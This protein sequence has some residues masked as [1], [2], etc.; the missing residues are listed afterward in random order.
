MSNIENLRITVNNVNGLMGELCNR[1]PKLHVH[2]SYN[3]VRLELLDD[4]KVYKELPCIGP[5]ECLTFAEG[6]ESA[7][8]LFAYGHEK[9]GAYVYG[10]EK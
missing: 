5:K 9:F 8:E 2:R 6:M 4:G 1:P 10:Y 3:R 7:L